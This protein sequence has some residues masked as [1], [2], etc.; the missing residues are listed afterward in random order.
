MRKLFVLCN[1]AMFFAL[2]FAKADEQKSA[3]QET[4]YMVT[5][6]GVV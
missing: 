3:E 5:M 4:A 2:A 1:A 6:T